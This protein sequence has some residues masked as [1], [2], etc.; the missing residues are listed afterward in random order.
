MRFWAKKIRKRNKTHAKQKMTGNSELRSVF[1]E[2]GQE[3]KAD[4]RK[5]HDL[6]V[7]RL[8]CDIRINP[9]DLSIYQQSKERQSGYPFVKKRNGSGLAESETEQAEEFNGQ[10]TGI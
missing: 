9:K 8:V 3:I 4:I 1:Q 2:F 5:R 6:Y 7:N 10:F